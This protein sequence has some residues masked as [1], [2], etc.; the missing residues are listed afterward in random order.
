MKISGLAI[1]IR[2][3]LCLVVLISSN[4]AVLGSSVR[5][6]MYLLWFARYPLSVFSIYI[7]VNS[8]DLIFSFCFET[9]FCYRAV[10]QELLLATT[11]N[12]V[13]LRS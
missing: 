1:A 13:Y 11:Y 7:P 12:I 10:F 4:V 6:D 9:S 3:I 5:V 2:A 8:N